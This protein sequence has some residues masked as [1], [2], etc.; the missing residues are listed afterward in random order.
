MKATL[1][2][3][4]SLI[5]TVTGTFDISSGGIEVMAT[6]IGHSIPTL[7]GAAD[8][9]YV[10]CQGGYAWP[11]WGRSA[12]GSTICAGAGSSANANCIS[13]P[14]STAGL[15]YGITGVCHQT[16]NR[17]LWPAGI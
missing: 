10:T 12:G 11:G 1:T 3:T 13:Q 5:Q 8:H 6:L 17:I 14:S 15:V 2:V 16:A 4:F 7:W 9:T